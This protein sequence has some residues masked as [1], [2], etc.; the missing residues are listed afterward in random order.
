MYVHILTN[1][2]ITYGRVILLHPPSSDFFLFAYLFLLHA[3][4][5]FAKTEP[6]EDRKDLAASEITKAVGELEQVCCVC[7][8]VCVCVCVRD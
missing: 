3:Q 2:D 4:Q 5:R 1:S 8:F 6:S 7:P